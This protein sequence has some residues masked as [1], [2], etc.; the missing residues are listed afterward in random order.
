MLLSIGEHAQSVGYGKKPTGFSVNTQRKSFFLLPYLFLILTLTSC[1]PVPV[2]IA[3][4]VGAAMMVGS[5][6]TRPRAP[7]VQPVAAAYESS[8]SESERPV[9][10]PI[11]LLVL[12]PVDERSQLEVDEERGGQLPEINGGGDIIG[13]YGI[14]SEEGHIRIAPEDASG[15][16]NVLHEMDSGM[17]HL[18]NIPRTV[19]TFQGLDATVQAGLTTYFRDAGIDAQPVAFSEP[20]PKHQSQPSAQ[21]TLGCRIEEFSL[22]SLRRYQQI[23]VRTFGGS[24]LVDIPIRGPT[25][26]SVSLRLT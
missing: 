12:R 22:F 9:L 15:D 5:K 4:H 13:F 7:Q 11:R 25:R 26:A 18:P 3:Y 23:R 14:N 17:S 16:L 2:F 24:H 10:L 21:Y 19:F 1:G 6:G 20:V 8:L